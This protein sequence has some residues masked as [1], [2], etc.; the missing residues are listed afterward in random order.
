MEITRRRLCCTVE[1]SLHKKMNKST[2]IHNTI[3]FIYMDCSVWRFPT[4]RYSGCRQAPFPM[5]SPRQ[6]ELLTIPQSLRDR[7][8]SLAS[9]SGRNPSTA[10]GPPPFRQWRADCHR[11]SPSLNEGANL[12]T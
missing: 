10:R 4:N 7:V 3:F 1:N 2:K 8:S 5:P 12:S 6:T 11:Q 9:A